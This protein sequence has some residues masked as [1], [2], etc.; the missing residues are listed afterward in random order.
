M[1][2]DQILKREEYVESGL[3]RKDTTDD[4]ELVIYTYT[5]KCVFDHIWDDI[6]I[7]SRGHIF[8]IKTGEVVARPFKKFFNLEPNNH[9][10]MESF[11]WLGGYEVYTKADGM[12]GVLFRHNG[13]FNVASRGSFHSDGSI[14]ATEFIQNYD[15]SCIPEEA[16]LVFEMI[17]QNLKIILDYP[18]V[19]T[20]IILAAFNRF[21]GEEYPR[22]T[23]EGWSKVIGLPIIDKHKHTLEDCLRHQKEALGSEG[24]VIRFKDGERVKIKTEFYRSLAK[25]IAF[26]SPIAIWESMVNGKVKLEFINQ[27]PLELKSL[28]NNYTHKLESQ[29][30]L[31]LSNVNTQCSV[32]VGEVGRDPKQVGLNR[33]KLKGIAYAA[34]FAWLRQDMVNLDKIIMKAIYP[35]A[36]EFVVIDTLPL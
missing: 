19:S 27:I 34:V 23:V 31:L 28:A 17:D 11:D 2:F 12:L 6:T 9:S 14:W 33:D 7:N 20:L 24:F 15:L 22:E 18:G 16:T 5:D 10:M 29:Y 13:K 25:L 26:L 21:T 32:F 36:N 3:L 8:N 30:S 4:S 35:R 1:S